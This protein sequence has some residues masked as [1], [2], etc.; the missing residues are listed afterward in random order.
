[1]I[2]WAQTSL[3]TTKLQPMFSQDVMATS[4][5]LA[6]VS[7]PDY[8]EF[9]SFYDLAKGEQKES[10]YDAIYGGYK[11]VQ[12]MIRKDGYK[13]LVYPKAK[14]KIIPFRKRSK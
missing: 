2:Y 11:K 10:H 7:K 12:R 14:G 4:L 9:N 13:L 6:G 1:M 3:R 8:V 5:E